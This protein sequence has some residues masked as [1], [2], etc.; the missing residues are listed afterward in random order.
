[1][2]PIMRE[3]RRALWEREL[4]FALEEMVETDYVKRK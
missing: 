2:A 4:I 3:L 1:M